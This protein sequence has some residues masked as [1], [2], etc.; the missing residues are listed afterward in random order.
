MFL[1]RTVITPKRQ[2]GDETA[3]AV[4]NDDFML[5]RKT[6]GTLPLL[7]SW[8]WNAELVFGCNA[9]YKIRQ[10]DKTMLL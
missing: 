2:E 4:G 10:T 9:T 6:V 3:T 5:Q 1:C 7:T 8:D